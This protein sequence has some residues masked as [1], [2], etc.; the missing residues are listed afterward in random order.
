MSLFIHIKSFLKKN[1]LKY[2]I[3]IILLVIVDALQLLTPLITGRFVDVVG[4][5][6]LTPKLIIFYMSAVILVTLGVALGRFGWRMTIIGIAKNLEYKIRDMVFNKLTTLNQVYFNNNKTGD[7]MARCTNDISTVRQAF[8]QGTILVIDSLFMAIMAIVLMITRVNL[9]LTLIALIPL[10]IVAI[11]ILLITKAIGHRFK[12]VQEAFS[13]ISDRAQESFSGIRIIKSFVQEKVNL[14]YFNESNKNNMDT[15][16][17]LVKIQGII[18]PFVATVGSVSLLISISYG[19]SLVIDGVISLGQLVS[20]ISLIGMMTWPMMAM[21]F[22]FTLMQ[23]GKVSL[24]RVNEILNA[25]DQID[26]VPTGEVLKDSSVEVN[27]L[28]FRYPGSNVNALEN[29][30]FYIEPGQSLAIVGHTGAGKSTLVELL[31]KTY[32]ISNG[33]IKIGQMDIN[34]L[35]LE[36]LRSNVGYVPQNNFLFSKTIN[37]NIAFHTDDINNNRVEKMAKIAMVHNEIDSLDKKF[38]TELGERGVNLS[39]GQKQRISIARAFY[40]SPEIIILDDSL[41]AVDTK[42]EDRILHHIR[43]ELK[44]KTAILISHRVSTVKDADKIIVLE[45]GKI[46]EQGTHE[47]LIAFDGYYNGLYQKQ[48]LQEKILEE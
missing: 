12:K 5:G 26:V 37:Q 20:F 39:G 10:P 11:V 43:E 14:H 33:E 27:N 48:L 6:E 24:T 41:S 29:I 42:T 21:G 31:L 44:D 17:N 7:I 36:K 4:S 45:E 38:L 19:G 25:T 28:T 46:I 40:K 1:M 35:S 30:S 18:H 15:T 32:K 3:G 9:K 23:R 22:V 16:L 47:S 13:I 8:G 2:I 34:S